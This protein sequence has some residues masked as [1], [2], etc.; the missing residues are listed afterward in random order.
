MKKAIISIVVALVLIA[1]A[2]PLAIAIADTEQPLDHVALSPTSVTLTINGTQQFTAVGQDSAN[3]TVTDVTYTWGVIAGSGN[4]T[5]SGLFTTAGTAG[6]STVQVIATQGG[7]TKTA[8][9]TV[10]MVVPGSLDHVALSPTSITLTIN[11]TQQFT[12]VGQDSA[13]LIV[14]G[15]G[16]TWGVIAGS[17]NI[18]ASGLFTAG[19]TAGTSTVQVIATQGG[20]IKTTL[21][22]VTVSTSMSEQKA[23]RSAPPGWEHGKKKGWGGEHTPPGWSKGNKRGWDNKGN[24]PGLMKA[25]VHDSDDDES[26]VED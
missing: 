12:A 7:I 24:P 22:K 8:L 23:D 1:A 4:I 6:T 5:A 25:K 17:G 2:M 20:I 11:G 10:T 14:T 13:N 15:V 21:A 9:A 16:Y 19:S 18:T 3:L 26:S